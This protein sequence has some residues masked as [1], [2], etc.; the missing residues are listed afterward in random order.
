MLLRFFLL[1]AFLCA[2]GAAAQAVLPDVRAVRSEAVQ[3]PET[4]LGP[5]SAERQRRREALRSALRSQEDEVHSTIAPRQ[6]SPQERAQ[7]RELL[8]RQTAA[9]G[10]SGP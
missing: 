9:P 6:L 1:G 3:A 10:G 8:R 5:G 2:E 7:L 4:D